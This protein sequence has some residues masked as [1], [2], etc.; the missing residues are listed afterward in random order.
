VDTRDSDD[1]SVWKVNEDTAWVQSVD[2]FT[3]VVDDPYD[4]GRIAA[5]NALSDLYAMGARPLFAL[6]I[7]AFPVQR[8]PLNVLHSILE[9]AG[10]VAREA[11]I[12]ILGG[13]TIEDNELK[14]GM[15]VNGIAHPDRILRNS[16]AQP[17]DLLV[18]TKP[19]GTGILSTALK[20]DRLSPGSFDPVIR[21]MTGL[22]RVP[23][24][25]FPDFNIH[26]V[27]DVTGFGLL[28]HLL[29][30]VRASKVSA[31]VY[32]D[33]VPVFQGVEDSVKAGMIPGGSQQNLDF[34]NAHVRW[35]GKVER[36]RRIV[37]ADA[38]TSGGLLISLPAGEAGDY[39]AKIRRAG[40]QDASIIG[41]I[42]EAGERSLIVQ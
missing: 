30:M 19:I 16:G 14:Y 20:R 27:T 32:S 37:L 2:F 11:E 38:Q 34:I 33:R 26:A 39:L 22:N 29:E 13:H 24:D 1:A 15:V 12:L 8:L 18:L 9:G 21:S 7:V 31:R 40:C 23:A 28:G 3:P 4:F 10:S 25:F 42:L 5:V 6:N 17:G 35:E 36:N 41:E